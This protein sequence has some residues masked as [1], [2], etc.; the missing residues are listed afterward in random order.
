[1]TRTTSA[2]GAE[3]RNDERTGR[4]LPPD[5]VRRLTR[6]DARRAWFAIIETAGALAIFVG[7]VL[8]T[9]SPWTVPPLLVLIAFRQQACFVLAHDAAHYRLFEN[10]T[11]N[12]VVGGLFAAIVGISMRTYRV[13]HRLHHN[14]LYGAQD[15]DVPLIA[16]YPRGKAYLAR[17]L[18][19]DLL[20]LTAFKTYAYFFG[21]PAIN[22]ATGARSRPLDDT[23]PALRAAA[24]RDRWFV[25]ALHVAMPAL[26]F[27]A[28]HAVEYL[29]LWLLP[30]LSILQPI[31]R[32]RALCE[33]AAVPDTAS[34]FH[35]ARTTRAP[36][37]IEW[38]LFPHHV[39][40]HLE[41][42]LY[43]SIPHYNLPDAHRELARH[44]LLAGAEVRDL[45]AAF[46]MIAADR[47]A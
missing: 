37:V 39:N 21:A 4:G 40:F 15:P 32:F 23:A 29:V 8:W 27:A 3:F 33:H 11:L 25:A 12:D 9:W 30:L 24:R 17:K 19:K 10:R 43:P 34:A 13:V 18:A 20:G 42:H 14:H 46:G 16:G 28:G 35:A 44:G 6:I 31:L 45:S 7:L 38:L 2:D 1:M 41:H 47:A 26:A 36:G 22:E 5:I